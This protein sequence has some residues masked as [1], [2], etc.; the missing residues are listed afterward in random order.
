[1]YIF[2]LHMQPA[3]GARLTL[4]SER[5]TREG[6]ILHQALAGEKKFGNG[7]LRGN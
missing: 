1:M 7:A 2:V 5:I 3:H 6:L 4:F